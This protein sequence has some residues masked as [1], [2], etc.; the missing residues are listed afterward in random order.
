MIVPIHVV[1]P[2]LVDETGH[3]HSF[4][5]AVCGSGPEQKFVLW[6]DREAR[7]DLFPGLDHV[8]MRP[9]FRR[10]WRKPQAWLLYRRLLQEPGR[11]FLPTAGVTDITILCHAARVKLRR[12][13]VSCFVH[14]I[15]PSASRLTR[16]A[17]AARRQPELGVLGP[18]DE[19][20]GFLREAG[21]QRARRVAYPISPSAR[22]AAEAS[23]FSHLLFAGAARMD[24]GFDRVVDLIEILAERGETLP[25]HLQTSARH[26]GKVDPE[27]GRQLERLTRVG[28]AG[29]QAHPDTLDS[30]RY[31]ELFRGAICLQ[32]YVQ[33]E[34]SHRVSAVTVDALGCGAPVLTTADTWM[35]RNV[36]R[37]GA[38]IAIKD[39]S[40]AELHA[41]LRRLIDDYPRYSVAARLAARTIQAEHAPRHLLDA[42]LERVRD[43]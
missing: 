15:R 30:A 37:L 40:G 27:I 9:H 35:G 21:F 8:E 3:C 39:P 23:D 4:I 22:P 42:V 2:T 38:G 5:G 11:I 12:G 20:V 10:R 25:V 26:Y 24:K 13:K 29:L 16:L 6:G 7:S 43:A 19:I 17:A 31:F 36:E 14:W 33:S 28:Y 41:A 18:T 1:E 32:P 34:F